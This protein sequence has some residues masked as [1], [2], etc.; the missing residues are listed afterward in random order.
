MKKL[1]SLM[2]LFLFL[3]LKPEVHAVDMIMGPNTIY[4]PVTSM[5]TLQDIT[6]LYT[7]YGKVITVEADNFT[8]NGA[9]PGTYE[10]SLVANDGINNVASKNIQVI[11]VDVTIT[12]K[13]KII[14]DSGNLYVTNTVALTHQEIINTLAAVDLIYYDKST[15]TPYLLKDDY[16][17]NAQ[18]PGYYQFQFRLIDLSGLDNTYQILIYVGESNQLIHQPID[19]GSN[20]NFFSDLLNWVIPIGII[21]FVFWYFQN[22]KSRGKTIKPY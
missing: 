4:K 21:Y 14:T 9:T 5:V 1:I 10:I 22:R 8:G 6:E 15:T 7:S 18:T 12:P 11:V 3:L 19:M 2:L 16:S 13:V 17:I 20:T